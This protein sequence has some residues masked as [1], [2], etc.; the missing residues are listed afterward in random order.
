MDKI[1]KHFHLL[2][3]LSY[4]DNSVQRKRL[5]EAATSEQIATF[6]EISLN[7]L[8][9]FFDLSDQELLILERYKSV[10]RKLADKYVANNEKKRSLIRYSISIKH[11][12]SVF[13]NH[14]KVLEQH[15]RTYKKT[16]S[17]PPDTIPTTHSVSTDKPTETS[18]SPDSNSS[19]SSNED[20]N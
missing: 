10:F 8:N 9:G 16:S 14:W 7:I 12:L 18:C 1:G 13:F 17:Y 20:D 4:S 3:Y 6:S 11:L 15:G 5:L 19:T 2:R